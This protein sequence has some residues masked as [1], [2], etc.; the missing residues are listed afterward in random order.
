MSLFDPTSH[1]LS[2]VSCEK[3]CVCARGASANEWMCWKSS[4]NTCKIKLKK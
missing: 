1:P 3:V 4:G 2:L